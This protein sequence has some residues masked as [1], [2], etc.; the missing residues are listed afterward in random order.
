MLLPK[1]V[2]VPNFAL[3]EVGVPS[4]LANRLGHV[5]QKPRSILGRRNSSQHKGMSLF[6]LMITTA[7]LIPPSALDHHDKSLFCTHHTT[8]ATSKIG[9]HD[10]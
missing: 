2:S 4:N 1:F 8:N 5:E 9:R 3:N 10:I 6:S 7:K